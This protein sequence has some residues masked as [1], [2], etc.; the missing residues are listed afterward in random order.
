VGQRENTGEGGRGREDK[1]ER[2]RLRKHELEDQ[3]YILAIRN[4][5]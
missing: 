3:V 4:A 1:E 5:K 2:E